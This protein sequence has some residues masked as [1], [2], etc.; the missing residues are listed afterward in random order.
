MLKVFTA[1]NHAEAHLVLGL[2][3][4]AG[5]FSEVRG[6]SLFSIEGAA[7]ISSMSPSVWVKDDQAKDAL[8]I[9]TRCSKGESTIG[10]EEAS[11]QCTGCGELHEPQFTDCWNCGARKP[12][13]RAL[14]GV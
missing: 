6:E 7:A 4:T 8:D 12:A 14:P 1:P 2:L 3:Q 5:I 13:H 9:I 11:W 10:S